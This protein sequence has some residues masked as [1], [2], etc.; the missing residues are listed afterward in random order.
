GDRPR[1]LSGGQAQRVAIARALATEPRLLLLDEPL[2]ALDASTRPSLRRD[3]VR[4]LETFPGVAVVVTHDPVEAMAL[5]DHIVV[6]EDG[7][8]TQTGDC[9]ELRERPRSDYVAEFVG[10]NLYRGTADADGLVLAN[11]AHLVGGH[12]TL[13][14]DALAVV[15]PRAVALHRSRPDG[16]PRNVWAGTVRHVDPEGD[17]VRVHVDAPVP[18][19]AEITASSLAE[20]GL[21][22]GMPVWASVKATEVT[23]FEA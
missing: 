21:G 2:S 17:R 10:V 18:V 4:H 12:G 1:A 9:D 19:T 11:G 8:V 7:R 5:A 16:T 20:L 13:R 14:G 15:H 22:A 3:L 6:L 23:V